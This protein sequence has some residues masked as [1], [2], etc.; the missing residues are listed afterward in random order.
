MAA[1]GT[2]SIVKPQAPPRP[3]VDPGQIELSLVCKS[4]GADGFAK[5]VVRDCSFVIQRGKLTVMIGPS[6]CGKSTLIRLLAGFERPTS[7][8]ITIGGKPGA[9][10]GRGRLVSFRGR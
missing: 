8:T 2:G 9:E 4:Y 6:G 5:D 3:A 7:G 10:P 1:T